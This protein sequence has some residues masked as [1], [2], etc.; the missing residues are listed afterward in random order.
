[1]IHRI[2]LNRISHAASSR[3]IERNGQLGVM[4][5]DMQTRGQVNPILVIRDKT[6]W[7]WRLRPWRYIVIDGGYR[8]EAAR[9]CEWKSIVAC[10]V[11]ATVENGLEGIR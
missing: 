3:P 9:I 8:L 10:V 7:F 4:V 1:M 2:R 11:E 6:R 5:V